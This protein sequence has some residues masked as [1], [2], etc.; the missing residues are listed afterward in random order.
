MQTSAPVSDR[1][2]FCPIGHTA[3]HTY[4]RTDWRRNKQKIRKLSHHY[5]YFL[6]GRIYA[7]SQYDL[8][9]C[10][11]SGSPLSCRRSCT[12]HTR[13]SPHSRGSAWCASV[14]WP[15]W[16]WSLRTARTDSERPRARSACGSWV[17]RLAWRPCRIRRSSRWSPGVWTSCGGAFR[18]CSW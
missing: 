15:C 5:I 16:R 3:I 13:T 10:A 2:A 8:H 1:R 9:S 4:I 7:P 18:L 14:G 12:P 6:P 11:S 17:L